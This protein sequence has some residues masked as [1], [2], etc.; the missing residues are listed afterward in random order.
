MHEEKLELL[1]DAALCDGVTE[2]A[3]ARQSIFSI[4]IILSMT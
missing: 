4:M 1:I 3:S 2:N